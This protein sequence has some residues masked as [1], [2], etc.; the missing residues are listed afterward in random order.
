M[1]DQHHL[2]HRP[3][4]AYVYTCVLTLQRECDLFY[5]EW[6]VHRTQDLHVELPTGVPDHMVA[7][8]NAYGPKI[9]SLTTSP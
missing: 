6:N 4:R 8:R 2:G 7:F 5:L 9:Q 1:N 3:L